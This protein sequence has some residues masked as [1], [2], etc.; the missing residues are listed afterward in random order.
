MRLCCVRLFALCLVV[1]A[2][3]PATLQAADINVIL[4]QARMVKLP[5]R[6]ATIVIGNPIIADAA[7]QSGGWMV[8]TGKGYGMTNIVAL[9]RTGAILMERTVE[10]QGPQ[11]VVVV[12]RGGERE[13]LSCTPECG[14]QLALGD[15][16]PLFDINAEQIIARNALGAGSSSAK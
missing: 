10:V 7:V 16:K 5:D 13:T 15:S 8:I 6:V 4:D 3:V 14:R 2:G 9:D 12:Y 11:N 1:A